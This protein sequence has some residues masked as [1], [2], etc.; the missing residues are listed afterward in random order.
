ML[1]VRWEMI[2]TFLLQD[3][4]AQSSRRPIAVDLF[5]GAGG[6]SLGIEQA[7]FDVAIAVEKDPVH[8]ATYRFNFPQTQVLWGDAA[9][10]SGKD[11][12]ELL[13]D[14]P[15]DLVFGGPPC[16]GF[17][18][19]GKHDLRDSRNSLV[20]HFCRLVRELQP[21]Y[22]LMENVPGLTHANN[23]VLL[24]RL[25][26]EFK[27]AGYKIVEPVRVLNAAEFGVPQTRKRL[28]LLGTR[29]GEALLSYPQ[30][31]TTRVTVRDAIADLPDLDT[32]PELRSQDEILLKPE[33]IERL[34]ATASTY[35]KQLRELVPDPE[36]FAYPRRWNPLLL[37][38][39]WQTQHALATRQRFGQ[40]SP[41]EQDKISRLRRLEW[42][43]CCYTLRAGTGADRGS[44]TA[45][46][47]LHPQYNRTISVRE[48]ARL[49]SF[50]DWFRLHATKWHGFRQIGNAVPPLLGR[51]LGHRIMQA[52]A[53]EPLKPSISLESGDKTLLRLKSKQAIKRM[54]SDQP[55]QHPTLRE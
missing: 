55:Y 39:S 40:L 46:R 45:P 48:A 22:F 30:P 21:R 54:Q 12:Q 44:H 5:A 37:T 33:R 53:L 41:G 10:L 42:A 18:V 1:N 9:T 16:Q 2:G 27:A 49:H 43:G 14:R 15:I 25:K 28:F 35:A 11:L 23:R 26:R 13:S 47:P 3:G 24:R 19:M 36:N 31:T 29:Q 50:P 17:S 34:E 7:G 52:I 6:F 8:A 38:G 32:F 51:V 4:M 20:F